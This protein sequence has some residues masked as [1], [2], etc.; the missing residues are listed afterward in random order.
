MTV[1]GVELQCCTC[2]VT[3]M[4][5]CLVSDDTNC[6]SVTSELPTVTDNSMSPGQQFTPD[7][8]CQQLYGRSSFHCAVS[9]QR[10]Y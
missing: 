6:L 9:I 5:V 8:Q 10:C 1:P 4:R 2:G 7:E 3:M